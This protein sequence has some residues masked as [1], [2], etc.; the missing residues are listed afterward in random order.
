MV[1]RKWTA[2]FYADVKGDIRGKVKRTI[3]YYVKGL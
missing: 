1:T 2:P 3:Y